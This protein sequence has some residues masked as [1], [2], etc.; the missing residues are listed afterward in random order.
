MVYNLFVSTYD[1]RVNGSFNK[2]WEKLAC[3]KG[4]TREVVLRRAL[5]SY[6][7]ITRELENYPGSKL[8]ITTL[9]DVVV[10]D[11]VLP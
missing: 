7:W 10:R 1:L 6:A 9:N 8:S 4:V 3:D 11:V 2:L 5:A